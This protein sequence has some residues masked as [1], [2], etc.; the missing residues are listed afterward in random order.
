VAINN[1][2]RTE[3]GRTRYGETVSHFGSSVYTISMLYIFCV[4]SALLAGTA[5]AL[6]GPVRKFRR[7]PYTVENKHVPYQKF[8]LFRERFYKAGVSLIVLL[9]LF[10]GFFVFAASNYSIAFAFSL[11]MMPAIATFFGLAVA[12]INVQQTYRIV[13]FRYYD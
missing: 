12:A 2:N 10:A 5:I 13:F 8:V 6:I 7:M 3:W 4:I 11:A 9:F 1:K